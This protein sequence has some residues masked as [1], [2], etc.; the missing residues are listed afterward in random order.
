LTASA[1]ARTTV[2]ADVLAKVVL[3][4]GTHRGLASLARAQRAGLIV[5]RDGRVLVSPRWSAY[6]YAD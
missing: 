2:M 3:L 1:I 6:A 5:R 4:L